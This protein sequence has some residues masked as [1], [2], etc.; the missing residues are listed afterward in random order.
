MASRR[1]TL[2]ALPLAVAV[3]A[4]LLGAG[5]G[6]GGGPAGST[7]DIAGSRTTHTVTIAADPNGR[8]QWQSD[9]AEASAGTVRLT[10]D[11]PSNVPH[12]LHITGH[13][14]DRATRVLADGTASITVRLAPGTYDFRCDVPGHEKMTGELVVG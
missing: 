5:C 2:T 9:R 11:N 14:V 10:L 12:D 13:G 6:G 4:G 7:S 3:A 1:H 8:L